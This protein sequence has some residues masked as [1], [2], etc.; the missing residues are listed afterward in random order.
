MAK[1]LAD[2]I[3][4]VLQQSF[5]NTEE[6]R[7]LAI[8]TDNNPEVAVVSSTLDFQ[9]VVIGER[10]RLL[11]KMYRKIQKKKLRRP[12]IVESSFDAVPLREGS[13]DAIILNRNIFSAQSPIRTLRE[14]CTLL[15]ADGLMIWPQLS[16]G[17]MKRIPRLGAKFGTKSVERAD[18]TS[19]AM[20]AGFAEI[21]QIVVSSRLVTWTITTGRNNNRL[22]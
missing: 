17:K 11:Y 18:L 13:L 14:M 21:G 7:H 19:M 12:L 9:T 16:P 4:N 15:R 3:V 20:E 1:P 10:F 5:P 6:E 22:E 8:I 2:A